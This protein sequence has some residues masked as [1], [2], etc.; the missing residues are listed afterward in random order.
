MNSPQ[1]LYI[2]QLEGSYAVVHLPLSVDPSILQPSTDEL[3]SLT[4]STIEY[5]LVCS[6]TQL[7]R[8]TETQHQVDLGWHAF[9]LQGPIDFGTCGIIARLTTPLA[10][11]SI[12]CFVLSTFDSDVVMVK[13]HAA[14]KAIGA[15]AQ[16]N[17]FFEQSQPL[18]GGSQNV[19]QRQHALATSPVENQVF[20]ADE[21]LSLNRIAMQL[22]KRFVSCESEA[23]A[24]AAA[25]AAL[26]LPFSLRS[27][28]KSFALDQRSSALLLKGFSINEATLMATPPSWDTPWEQP[29]IHQLE[30]TQALIAS[31]FGEIFG[32]HT[33]E[34]GRFFRHIIPHPADAS[35]QLGSSSTVD[36]EWHNEEAIHPSRADWVVLMCYRNLERAGT[37]ICPTS[38]LDL[39]ADTEAVL[40][41]DR[42][43]IV[44][45]KSHRSDFN[46]SKHWQLSS[47]DFARIERML[48]SPEPQPV[49]TGPSEFPYM[50]I[51][52]AFMHGIDAEAV[53]ALEAIKAEINRKLIDVV[54]E[55]GDFLIINNLRTVHGRR[56]Y[57]PL[58]G[59]Q[60]RWMR[61]VNVACDVNKAGQ[62]ITIGTPRRFI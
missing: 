60:Q 18:A 42:F 10:A 26:E 21:L 30:V 43:I 37:T 15:W 59:P 23:F 61:R 6:E 54:I 56:A 41:T 38:I 7:S 28:A 34:N 33:Q 25:L 55:A 57:R 5:S 24:T 51:D 31:L 20:T 44:P 9:Y 17:I 27:K 2:R 19:L 22:A 47:E 52:P 29:L 3:W 49:L 48:G 39:E 58:Y 40:R 13:G 46:Q 36:L 1:P 16:A 53:A 8:Y 62:V 11:E 35:E 32:W 14:Q 50:R 12:G 4:R 45:D